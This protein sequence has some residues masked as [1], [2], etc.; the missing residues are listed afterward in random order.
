MKGRS[1]A[2]TANRTP[3]PWRGCPMRRSRRPNT[4]DAQVPDSAPTAVA[5]VS[6]VKTRND[7]IGVNSDVEVG[8]CAGSKGKEVLS[9]AAMAERAGQATGVVTTARI[10]HAT[11]AAMYAHT[12]HRDWEGDANMPAEA[13][14][15][16]CKDIAQQLVAW[17]HGDGF[18]VI[19]GGGRD[20]LLPT[21]ADDPEDKNLKGSRKDGRNL[22]QEWLARYSNS[23]SFVWNKERF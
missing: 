6:G 5:M 17:P 2:S 4:H 15:A 22:I 1:A 7:V 19:L 18:E 13:I 9:L 23:G 21:T 8:D 10:T 20:R 14:A 16:G 11:P 12:P 3:S